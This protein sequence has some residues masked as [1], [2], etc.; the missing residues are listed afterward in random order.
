MAAGKTRRRRQPP[1][2]GCG[3]R[4]SAGN[5]R[6]VR[7]ALRVLARTTSIAAAAHWPQPRRHWAAH[8]LPGALLALTNPEQIIRHPAAGLYSQSSHALVSVGAGV[9]AGLRKHDGIGE[10]NFCRSQQQPCA[11][12]PDEWPQQVHADRPGRLFGERGGT[13]A[14]DTRKRRGR[15]GTGRAQRRIE[16]G[17]RGD[18]GGQSGDTRRGG[19]LHDLL[20]AQRLQ[21]LLARPL[22]RV[23][24]VGTPQLQMD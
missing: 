1:W 21:I 15:R 22:R 14:E 17:G 3:K 5:V 20:F 19:P 24:H 9:D 8:V 16:R 23:L 18:G 13:R 4:L 11:H 7:H 10:N 2:P 12:A 6:F